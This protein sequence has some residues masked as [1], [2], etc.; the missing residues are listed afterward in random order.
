MGEDCVLSVNCPP[1]RR[2]PHALQERIACQQK[3]LEILGWLWDAVAGP[4][5]HALGIDRAPAPG[6]AWP[7]VWWV[8]GGSLSLLPLHAAGHHAQ[9]LDGQAPRTVL[10][11][12]V[13]SYTPTIRALRFSREHERLPAGPAAEQSLIVAMPTTPGL[14][15]GAPLPHAATEASRLRV[16]LPAPVLLTQPRT[17]GAAG[18]PTRAAVLARL[19]QCAIAHFACHG[20]THTEDPS[21][22]QL[23]LSDHESD[24]LTVTRLA[25]VNLQRARLAYLS[26]CG[27]A[28]TVKGALLDEAIHLTSACQLAG[29]PHVV[30]TLW[31]INDARQRRS[32]CHLLRRPSS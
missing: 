19:P 11:R 21:Q 6:E 29:F 3:L 9:R 31:D 28:F 18:V 12:A 8:S 15:D 30:G 14:P 16:L 23:L 4:V 32:R 27:T 25:P 17:E 24:P 2:C 10:D 20:I 13:S 26:A 1:D 5:L 22:S 7:H